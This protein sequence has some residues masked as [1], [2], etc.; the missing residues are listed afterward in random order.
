VRALLLLA[1]AAA[2][3][4]TVSFVPPASGRLDGSPR[5]LCR[6][7]GADRKESRNMKEGV[8][9][10]IP[11]DLSNLPDLPDFGEE[12]MT[13]GKEGR[14]MEL[15]DIPLDEDLLPPE[16]NPIMNV[17]LGLMEWTGIWA[18]LLLAVAAI[19]AVS[20][21]AFSR[22][23]IDPVLAG[24]LLDFLRPTLAVYQALFLARAVGTQFPQVK[25]TDW[26]Y[27]ICYYPT[28]FMLAP[29]RAILKPEGGVDVTPFLWVMLTALVAELFA[30][31]FGV[32]QMFKDGARS[33]N[34]AP[35]S[36]R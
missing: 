4:S 10:A 17:E 21:W 29:T 34:G 16:P 12:D 7:A 20:S 31:S 25:M 32:L 6:A 18:L 8:G 13:D 36:I 14:R 15:P 19:I 26:P 28:E 1:V 35:L 24:Q 33:V 30:G 9:E 22:I 3:V 11:V 2:T 27:A 23:Q 5:V